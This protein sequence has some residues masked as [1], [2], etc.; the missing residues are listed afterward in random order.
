MLRHLLAV[1]TLCAALGL[2]SA[3]GSED[4]GESAGGGEG[5]T[6]TTATA[7]ATDDGEGATGDDRAD[8]SIAEDP[9]PVSRQELGSMIA[10]ANDE[11]GQ[12]IGDV[13][14]AA[15][16][17]A[18]RTALEDA[19]ETEQRHIERLEEVDPPQIA[20]R[21]VDQLVE[22][23]RA[24]AERFRELAERED[25]S[26]EELQKRFRQ[27]SEGDRQVQRAFELLERA[28]ISAG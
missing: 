10:E 15:D 28:G 5:T 1:L 18:I 26:L 24:Q 22:G 9:S 20:E 25:L 19:A 3:C 16:A 14:Q 12:A 8:G 2:V 4:G 6:E 17:D 27:E 7:P 21:A 23:G 11:I 13:E